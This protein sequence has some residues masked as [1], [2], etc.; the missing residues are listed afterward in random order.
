M[1][2]AGARRP[3]PRQARPSESFWGRSGVRACVRGLWGL[4][5]AWVVRQRAVRGCV[6]LAV[7]PLN[8]PASIWTGSILAAWFQEAPILARGQSRGVWHA[9]RPWQQGERCCRGFG[10][11]CGCGWGRGGGVLTCGRCG[12]C[13]RLG[14]SFGD[15]TTCVPTL[16]SMGTR[17]FESWSIIW[18]K[19]N[20]IISPPGGVSVAG[21]CGGGA[22]RLCKWAW[23]TLLATRSWL[24]ARSFAFAPWSPG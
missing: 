7:A 21:W 23:R 11:A 2:W 18:G 8:N 4:M 14:G 22:S 19:K 13:R 9:Y 15:Q 1:L 20:C 17:G 12:E 6:W 24:A 3:R 10:D 16:A 5:W